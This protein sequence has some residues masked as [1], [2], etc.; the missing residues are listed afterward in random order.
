MVGVW[1]SGSD[2]AYVL[3]W[4]HPP[5]R[6]QRVGVGGLAFAPMGSLESGWVLHQ[7]TEAFFRLT[8][9][10]DGERLAGWVGC[11]LLVGALG[12][13]GASV[14]GGGLKPVVN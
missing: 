12:W 6:G 1:G 8:Y 13:N 10:F 11:G 14:W 2:V 4:G 5:P 3:V 9:F 7:W